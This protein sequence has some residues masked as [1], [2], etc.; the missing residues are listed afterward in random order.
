MSNE[1]VVGDEILSL[2]LLNAQGLT[3]HKWNEWQEMIDGMNSSFRIS[4]FTET[5]HKFEKVFL[6]KDYKYEVGMRSE[7]DKKGGGLLVGSNDEVCI[8]KVESGNP[9][10]LCVDVEIRSVMMRMVLTYWDVRDNDRNEGIVGCIRRIVENYEG[11]L[12]ILGDMNAH[13]GILGEQE[14]NRNGEKLLNVMD[15][16]RLVLLN[17]DE[18]CIG[19]ITRDDGRHK[20]VIDFVLVNESMYDNFVRMNIDEKKDCFDLSDHCMIRIDFGITMRKRDESV[21]RKIEYFS[22]RDGLKE[23]FAGDGREFD[24]IKCG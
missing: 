13:I 1:N 6:G 2:F 20:S 10:V 7:M 4:L 14:L 23:V 12:I 16:C 5:Q 9:D 11:K 18:E 15:E 21:Q 22:V 19:E 8:V 17:L 3:L 24:E